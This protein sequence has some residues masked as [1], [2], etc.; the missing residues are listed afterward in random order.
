MATRSR[1]VTIGAACLAALALTA[2]SAAADTFRL[3]PYKD[4]LF[5]LPSPSAIAYD[6]DYATIPFDVARDVTA[7]D[8]IP[9]KKAKAEYVSLDVNK[10]QADLT[11]TADGATL[12]YFAVG[13]TGGKARAIVVYVHGWQ[14]NRN[15]GVNDWTFGGNFNRLKN[16]VA[17]SGGVYVSPD[18]PDRP[19]RRRRS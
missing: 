13:R 12:K 18:F 4:A 17:K 3:A 15:D 16:L 2:G 9:N 7:R 11:F 10:E 5:K 19:T 8:E 6:G 14:A 1:K